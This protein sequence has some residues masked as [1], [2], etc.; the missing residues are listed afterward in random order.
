MHTVQASFSTDENIMHIS[1][2]S[3]V[4]EDPAYPGHHA[5]YPV[6]S[7]CTRKRNNMDPIPHYT[8][9]CV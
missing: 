7:R 4:L 9:A 3:G 5:E 2:E 1:Y 6:R 8:N